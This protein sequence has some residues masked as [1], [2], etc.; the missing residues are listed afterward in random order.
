MLT[1]SDQTISVEDT[2][3]RGGMAYTQGY[4]SRGLQLS[5]PE[6]DAGGSLHDIWC[7]LSLLMGAQIRSLNVFGFNDSNLWLIGCC[8][9]IM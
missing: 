1:S 2:S 5:G 8:I 3:P 4:V 7:N 9:D 6:E